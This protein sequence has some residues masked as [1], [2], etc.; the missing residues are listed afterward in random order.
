MKIFF[1]FFAH[2]PLVFKILS[3]ASIEITVLTTL[4]VS[5]KIIISG[6]TVL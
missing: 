2:L 4:L 3:K 1:H 5:L 6:R